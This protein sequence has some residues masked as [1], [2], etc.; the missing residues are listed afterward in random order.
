MAIS[1][2]P[3]KG[4]SFSAPDSLMP[5]GSAQQRHTQTVRLVP[6]RKVEGLGFEEL[7][8]YRE[9][10]IGL[11]HRDIMAIRNQT[12]LAW[13]WRI[14]APTFPIISYTV[15]F[16]HIGKVDFGQ[17]IPYFFLI[18]A[19]M[20][21]WTLIS[22][23]MIGAVNSVVGNAS[24]FQK[25]YFP[26]IILPI[27]SVTNTI[28]DFLLT[29][30]LLLAILF[31]MG[32]PLSTNLFFVPF[33]GLW[34]LLFGLGCGLWLSALNVLYRDVGQSLG[35][36]IQIAFFFSPVVYPTEA[37]PERF[38]DLYHLN[39]VVGIID[40]FRWAFLEQG[41]PP[42]ESDFWAFVA[43]CLLVLSGIWF[44]RKLEKVFADV[45]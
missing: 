45:V 32:M 42:S 43:T 1:E 30:L 10:V 8:A 23:I 38:R 37:V 6:N 28:V 19:A 27:V 36:L 15:L 41:S 16:E 44:F 40:G 2:T 26:R 21:P 11:F 9:L 34:A 39:P 22:S 20:I 33:F 25:V 24:F 4:E 18:S 17:G 13:F 35:Y 12:P 29:C 31:Y 3:E 14:L 5:E 7:W